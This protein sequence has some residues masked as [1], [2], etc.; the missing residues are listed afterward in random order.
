MEAGEPRES[1]EPGRPKEAAQTAPPV[2][3]E[4]VTRRF[5]DVEVLRGISLRVERGKTVCILGGS[6]GGKS[7]L[8]RIMFGALR[9]TTGRVLVEGHEMNAL[10]EEELD[11]VRLKFGVMFQGGA[12][13]NSMTVAENVALPLRYHTRLDEETVMTLVKMKLQLVDLLPAADRRPS[14]ISGGM[15]KRAAVARALALDPKLIF[16][17]E[18]SAGLDPI[19][20]HRIDSLI[21]KLKASMGITNV[22]V[23]HV[24]ESVRRIADRVIMLHGGVILLD[25]TLE[26]LFDSDDP[27]VRSFVNGDLEGL[28]EEA[29]SRSTF[30]KDLLME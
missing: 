27:H 2:E 9:P 13:L 15:R 1:M 30:F 16:Y 23:T 3:V 26:D 21:N 10:G 24:L 5:D 8:L 4:D 6:G 25:G 29:V 7:T 11:R 20:T 22:V 14:E 18:P 12:L 28:A 17:D 19:A